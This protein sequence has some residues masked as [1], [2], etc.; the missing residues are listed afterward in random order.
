MHDGDQVVTALIDMAL[1]DPVLRAGI[2]R[3]GDNVFKEWAKVNPRL[4]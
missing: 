2:E 3:L 1:D 4:L